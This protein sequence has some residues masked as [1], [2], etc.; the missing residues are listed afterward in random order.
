MASQSFEE[1]LRQAFDSVRNACVHHGSNLAR[2]VRRF[3]DQASNRPRGETGE[4]RRAQEPDSGP[5]RASDLLAREPASEIGR[6]ELLGESLDIRK[7][8]VTCAE[9]VIRKEVVTELQLIEVPV[10]RE[11]L[12]VE[13]RGTDGKVLRM[14]RDQANEWRIVLAEERADVRTRP[15]VREVVRVSKRKVW[16]KRAVSEPLRHEELRVEQAS[17]EDHDRAA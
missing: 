4:H 2:H 9:V 6:L 16:E 17:P 1:A 13:R 7:E 5:E 12:V 15:V 8:L 11:E 10:R 3:S 14:D